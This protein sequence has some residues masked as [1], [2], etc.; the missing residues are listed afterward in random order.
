M[1]RYSE[2]ARNYDK[3]DGSKQVKAIENNT[4]AKDER[5]EFISERIGL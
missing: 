1:I 4:D 3:T 5:I 2:T